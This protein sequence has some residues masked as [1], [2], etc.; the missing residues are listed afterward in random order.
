MVNDFGKLVG[1]VL[2]ILIAWCLAAAIYT[3]W[4]RKSK[5]IQQTVGV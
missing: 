1:N 4:L 5:L 2:I 3:H